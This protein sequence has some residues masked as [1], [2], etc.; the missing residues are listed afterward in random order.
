MG[1]LKIFKASKLFPL[2][3][4][5]KWNLLIRSDFY[6]SVFSILKFIDKSNSTNLRTLKNPKN[7]LNFEA[8]LS[9]HSRSN[10]C[11]TCSNQ[12]SI[13]ES[14]IRT[15]LNTPSFLLYIVIATILQTN[16]RKPAKLMRWE[17]KESLTHYFLK[18]QHC[19]NCLINFIDL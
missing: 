14:R 6:T 3:S 7:W 5:K 12:N 8:A 1:V 10:S 17:K 13:D 19:L 15:L 2:S 16:T 11:T 9:H 4:C 18:T